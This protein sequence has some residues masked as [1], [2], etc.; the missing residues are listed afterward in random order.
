MKKLKV[1]DMINVW[2][3]DRRILAILPYRGLYTQ[4]FNCVIR[5]QSDTPSG[6]MEMAYQQ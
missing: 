5:F 1:G 2:T 6:W 4:W 3:T